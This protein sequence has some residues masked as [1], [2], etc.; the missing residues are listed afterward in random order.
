MLSKEPKHYY[1][2]KQ[3]DEWL[4]RAVVS[5]HE[6]NMNLQLTPVKDHDVADMFWP[7]S[8]ILLLSL[9]NCIFTIC[10]TSSADGNRL[11]SCIGLL[12]LV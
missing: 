5:E 6:C 7:D 2:L 3:K 9:T 1:E 11:R 12:L 10:F 4:G 8:Y